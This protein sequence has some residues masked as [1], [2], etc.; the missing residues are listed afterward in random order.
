MSEYGWVEEIVINQ[1]SNRALV[2]VSRFAR[3]LKQVNG[4]RLNLQDPHLAKN[5]V[6]VMNETDD[7][8]LKKIFDDLLLE[9]HVLAEGEELLNSNEN[10]SVDVDSVQSTGVRFY[11]GVP[12]EPRSR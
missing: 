11:R 1:L 5:V 9:F 4:H 2:L 12:I 6:H 8:R 3:I 7:P 10:I